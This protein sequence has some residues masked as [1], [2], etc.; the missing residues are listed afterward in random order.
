MINIIGNMFDNTTT[1]FI[2][3]KSLSISQWDI[4]NNE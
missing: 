4:E 2:Q 3:L 1:F